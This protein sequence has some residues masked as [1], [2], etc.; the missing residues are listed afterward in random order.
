MCGK[1][2]C[3]KAWAAYRDLAAAIGAS[4]EEGGTREEETQTPGRWANVVHL[5]ADPV[6]QIAQRRLRCSLCRHERERHAIPLV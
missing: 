3:L 5:A 6:H 4:K 1:F 2:R